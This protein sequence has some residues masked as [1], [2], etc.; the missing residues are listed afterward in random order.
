MRS[1]GTGW[2]YY[3]VGGGVTNEF[4]ADNEN[5]QHRFIPHLLIYLSLALARAALKHIGWH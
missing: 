4:L 5:Q 2:I 1:G 3:S